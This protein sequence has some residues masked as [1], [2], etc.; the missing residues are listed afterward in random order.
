MAKKRKVQ[1]MNEEPSPPGSGE[2][3]WAGGS[4][5]QKV[6]REIRR[7]D[8]SGSVEAGTL[9]HDLPGVGPHPGFSR[10]ETAPQRKFEPER[11]KPTREKKLKK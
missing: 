6:R 9:P 7:D 10:G 11:K 2:L 1:H 5:E 8:I 3:G 4:D